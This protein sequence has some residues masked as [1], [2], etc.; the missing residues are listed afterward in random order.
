MTFYLK[1][2]TK[3]IMNIDK[4]IKDILQLL[5]DQKLSQQDGVRL[6]QYVREYKAANN[7]DFLNKSLADPLIHR[8]ALN[9][10]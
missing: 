6:L 9:G 4:L 3:N 5:K 8:K 1:G 7:I 10:A 2:I